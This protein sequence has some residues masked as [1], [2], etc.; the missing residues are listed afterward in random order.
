MPSVVSNTRKGKGRA[1]AEAALSTGA[2]ALSAT[3]E[4]EGAPSADSSLESSS[5]SEDNDDGDSADSDAEVLGVG[6]A[7]DDQRSGLDDGAEKTPALKERPNR[8]YW[9]MYKLEEQNEGGFVYHERDMCCC[10]PRAS[11]IK[12]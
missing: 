11:S 7:V 5:S 10:C 9:S 12:H 3:N 2:T 4:A 6:K 1:A 8:H